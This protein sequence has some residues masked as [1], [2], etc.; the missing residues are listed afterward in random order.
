MVYAHLF[1]TQTAEFMHCARCNELVYVRCDID[2]RSYGLVVAGALLTPPPLATQRSVDHAGESLT[3]RL[4][5]RMSHW[6]PD[7]VTIEDA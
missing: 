4:E 1:E 2:G 3:Q 7:I 6:I 5:R